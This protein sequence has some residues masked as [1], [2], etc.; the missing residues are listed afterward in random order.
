VTIAVDASLALKWVLPEEHTEEAW[1]LLQAWRLQA[2]TL[3]APPIFRPEVANALHR[4]ARRGIITGPETSDALRM[5]TPTIVIEEP[6]GLYPR[7]LT[8]AVE[9]RL[10]TVY[11]A[12]Y[13]ALAEYR[14]CELWT[15]D[16]RLVRAVQPQMPLVHWV[17]EVGG[18]VGPP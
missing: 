8:L 16:R 10:G 12:L 1:A 5:L 11:D 3:I 6:A 17:G 7:A 2:E 9:F 4:S 14:G 13:V 15:G 18:R